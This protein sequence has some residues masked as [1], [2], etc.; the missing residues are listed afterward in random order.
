MAV[1][2]LANPTDRLC[3]GTYEH[4]LRAIATDVGLPY[5]NSDPLDTLH[6]RAAAVLALVRRRRAETPPGP[7]R[8][9]LRGIGRHLDTA[10]HAVERAIE[11]AK[12]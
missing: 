3:A 4:D 7:D 9:K 12:A 5:D 10:V 1:F 11:R 6:D 8:A 2:N